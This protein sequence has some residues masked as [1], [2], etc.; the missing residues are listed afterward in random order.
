MNNYLMDSHR[1]QYEDSKSISGVFQFDFFVWLQSSVD[2]T[3]WCDDFEI[4][5]KLN[6]SLKQTTND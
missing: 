1:I 2:L 3:F 4:C 5:F 6:G